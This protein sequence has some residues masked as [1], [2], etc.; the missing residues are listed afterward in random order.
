[1]PGYPVW[2]KGSRSYCI[3]G[4][5]SDFQILKV[6]PDCAALCSLLD[7]APK[8]YCVSPNEA[9]S[10]AGSGAPSRSASRLS[11]TGLYALSKS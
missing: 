9:L 10:S 8:T 11:D 1:M 2:L 4:G 6:Q 5:F 7:P 3:D